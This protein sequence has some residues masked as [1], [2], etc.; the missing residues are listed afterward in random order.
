M[1]IKVTIMGSG[2]STGVPVLGCSCEVCQSTNSKNHR[3]RASILVNTE[4]GIPIV[5]DTGPEFRLQTLRAGVTSLQHV[6]YTHLHADHCHGFDDLRGLYFNSGKQIKCFLDEE[7]AQELRLRFHYAFE[8]TGYLGGRADIQLVDLPKGGG[9]FEVAG[10]TAETIRLPHGNVTTNAFS[11]GNFAYATD[12][13][14]FPE[15]QIRRWRGKVHTMVASG[16]RW[17]PH[18]THSAIEETIELFDR[19]GVTRG[20]IS[21]LSHDV[22]YDRD[23]LKMPQGVELAYDGLTF[24]V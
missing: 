1:T 23:R 2:T 19:L 18:K 13:K 20:I 5:I 7:Y 6:L 8:D 14:F 15:E 12:F 17:K 24:S 10:T 3:W 11:F 21:H 16:V 22:D 9:D 4:A